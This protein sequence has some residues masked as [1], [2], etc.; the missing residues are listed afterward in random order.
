MR[1]VYQGRPAGPDERANPSL[2]DFHAVGMDAPISEKVTK[3]TK[4]GGT[5]KERT[6]VLVTKETKIT[7]KVPGADE[8]PSPGT[9]TKNITWIYL[10]LP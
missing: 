10:D 9:L 6:E 8:I 2:N 1:G 4:E 7:E 3:R 5:N